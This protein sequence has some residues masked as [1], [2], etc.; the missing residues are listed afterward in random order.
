[1]VA[2]RWRVPIGLL[3]VMIVGTAVALPFI[4]LIW[5]AGRVGGQAMQH[6]PPRGRWWVW[7][8]RF[9]TRPGKSE[10]PLLWSL[11]W[12]AA[13]ATAAIVPEPCPRLG[14]PPFAPLEC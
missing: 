6:Q 8:A 13:A 5:R 10:Q 2:R 7:L 14:G 12:T 1:M 4:G 11:I 9:A 3:L